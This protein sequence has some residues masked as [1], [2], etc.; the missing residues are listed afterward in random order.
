MAEGDSARLNVPLGRTC[1]F[2]G[3]ATLAF[4]RD[5]I[6]PTGPDLAGFISETSALVSG[7]GL[8]ARN[9]AACVQATR[10]RTGRRHSLEKAPHFV[11]QSIPAVGARAFPKTE[12]ALNYASTGVQELGVA[13]FD[14]NVASTQCSG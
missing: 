8:P 7:Y 2:Q 4:D 5:T 6:R 13:G 12:P 1:E 14:L 3:A 10:A 9:L 11:C